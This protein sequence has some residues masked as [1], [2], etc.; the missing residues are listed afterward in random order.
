MP[1]TATRKISTSAMYLTLVEEFALYIGG[2]HMLIPHITER[3]LTYLALA[4]RPVARVRL[5]G[6]LWPDCSDCSASKRLRTA[7][8]RLR[9]TDGNLVQISGDRLC[10]DPQV[11][12]DVFELNDLAQRLVHAPDSESLAQVQLLVDRVELLP[13][14]DEE[15]LMPNREWYRLT[16]LAALENAAHALL[17]GGRPGPALIAALA[18]VQTEPLRESARRIVIRTHLLQGNAVEAMRERHR[19][20]L[21]LRSEFGVEPSAEMD[22]LL[23]ACFR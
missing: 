21:L 11:A 6:T 14:W 8:W 10:L 18:V 4:N 23:S 12:V 15:W 17:E 16:R 22:E 2:R 20:G 3:V 7:L 13:D 9:Q 19:Y 1:Q 5:A